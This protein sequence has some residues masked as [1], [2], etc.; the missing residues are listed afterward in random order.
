MKCVFIEGIIHS[1]IRLIIKNDIYSYEYTECAICMEFNKE[2]IFYPCRHFY[3]CKLC[4]KLFESCP[5]CR[6]LII[7]KVK[8]D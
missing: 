1:F 3:C 4:S 6:S 7:F 8:H 5:I 2:I